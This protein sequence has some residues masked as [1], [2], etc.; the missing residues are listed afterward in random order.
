MASITQ[1]GS[2][3]RAQIRKNGRSLSETF[4]SQAEA[5]DWAF[6]SS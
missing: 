3:W 6:V 1:R 2:K 5:V 4:N